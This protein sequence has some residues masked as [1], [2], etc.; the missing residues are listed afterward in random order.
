[1]NQKQLTPLSKFLSLVL[2]HSPQTIGI[3]LDA[4]G[5]VEVDI[6]IAR[7]N[8]FGKK[9][10]RKTLE[11][12][13]ATNNKKRFAFDETNTLIRASQGHSINIELGYEEKEPPAFLYHGTAKHFIDSIFK[14][15]LIKGSR[16]HVHLSWEKNTAIKVGQRHGEPVVLKVDAQQMKI[17]GFS[18]FESENGVWLTDHVPVRYL[19]KESS[20]S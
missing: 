19:S 14:K 16:H 6:L 9:I 2:R 3:Q 11:L 4:Q 12:V 17:D 8:S 13:V 18:F 20:V 1:M 10:D 5:W 15:G 7:M